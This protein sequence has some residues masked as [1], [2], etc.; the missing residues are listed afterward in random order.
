M[1]NILVT[2]GAGF[3]GSNFIRHL[4][5]RY[6]DIQVVNLDALTYAG[7]L[8]NLDGVQKDARYHFVKGDICDRSLVN[9]L[10]QTYRI[11]TV[12]HFAAQSHV[13][14]SIRS[15]ADFVTTNVLGTQILLDAAKQ[16]W[17]L[18][19]NN[20]HSR[21]YLP[22][23]RFLQISTD[24]VYGSSGPDVLFTEESPLLPNSPYSASKASADLLVR[25]YNQTY[26]LPVTITRCSNNYGPCQFPEKL[27]PL[28]IHNALHDLP[29]PV[30]G[31][32]L[33]IRD[34]LYVED[35]CAALCAVLEQGR[36]GE[37]YNIGGNCE[38]TNLELVTHL[39]RAL[40][41][42]EELITHVPDRPGHDFRYTLDCRK[43]KT[44]LGWQ[45]T[46]TFNAG[47]QSTLDWYLA[48]TDWMERCLRRQ[49]T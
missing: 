36:M 10:F 44:E 19:P 3:I 34:W 27:I 9:Q 15:P 31:D 40:G 32:G 17:N 23:V 38:T 33:Q 22:G 42:R 13:D 30:Y 39:L 26:G 2:G 24:E 12:V 47:I 35:H 4:L 20:T 6:R 18:E 16:A 25:S 37:V 49:T 41:K 11:D 1:K 48:H 7:N 46:Y 8:E 29:I 21:N 5:V 28:C 43:I 45:P 14:R